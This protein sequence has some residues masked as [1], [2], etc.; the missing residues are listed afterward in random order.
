MES[1]CQVRR[2]TRR[3]IAVVLS[4]GLSVVA[5]CGDGD[6]PASKAF[7]QV[8]DSDRQ[9]MVATTKVIKTMTDDLARTLAAADVSE[10]RFAAKLDTFN[11]DVIRG[12]AKAEEIENTEL[13]KTLGAYFLRAAEIG[14]V[15]A[16]IDGAFYSNDQ[17]LTDRLTR[18]LQTAMRRL[19]Q[20][21]SHLVDK[22]TPFMSADQRASLRRAAE[23][24]RR[25][26]QQ[27]AG[28]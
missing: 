15:L 21:D 13:R 5:G 4:C 27:L 19:G 7:G 12:Q 10:K 23:Q 24:S 14:D 8:S 28:T 3:I 6:D 17:A 2:T 22:I 25:R 9:A 26:F 1:H 16:R 11:D 20:A 18:D